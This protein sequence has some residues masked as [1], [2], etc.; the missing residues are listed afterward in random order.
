MDYVFSHSRTCVLYMNGKLSPRDVPLQELSLIIDLLSAWHNLT[1]G[2]NE[3][4]T[5]MASKWCQPK[6]PWWKWVSRHHG[7]KGISIETYIT[8]HHEYISHKIDTNILHHT[9]RTNRNNI[10]HLIENDQRST[11][12]QHFIYLNY[13]SEWRMEY[14]ILGSE[15]TIKIVALN[16]IESTVHTLKSDTITPIWKLLKNRRLSC[17]N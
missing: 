9:S 10:V 2:D 11:W 3:Y 1:H 16:G 13:N 14:S 4:P 8:L 7:D 6:H 15:C 17:K 5:I 12:Q